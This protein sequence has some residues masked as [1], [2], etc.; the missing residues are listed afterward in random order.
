MAGLP[1][2]KDLSLWRELRCITTSAG[3]MA[4]N[5]LFGLGRSLAR[6]GTVRHWL[7]SG[8][9]G[10]VDHAKRA[11]VTPRLHH[12]CPR[13]PCRSLGR[14]SQELSQGSPAFRLER[15]PRWTSAIRPN[16]FIHLGS[17][18]IT[19]RDTPG[20]AEDGTTYIVGTWPEDA[21]TLRL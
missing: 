1:S 6:G 15:R 10:R 18:R 4:V 5:C 9:G 2:V 7:G 19:H 20:H 3:G 14:H 11:P 8:T 16:D 13:G 17:L 21:R 12:A